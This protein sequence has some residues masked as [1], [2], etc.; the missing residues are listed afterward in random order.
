MSISDVNAMSSDLNDEPV[1]RELPKELP[2]SRSRFDSVSKVGTGS[3][4]GPG[5]PRATEGRCGSKAGISSVRG[6]CTSDGGYV[7]ALVETVARGSWS[8]LG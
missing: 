6:V 4:F 7:A 1:A 2:E 3:R 5:T 8:W